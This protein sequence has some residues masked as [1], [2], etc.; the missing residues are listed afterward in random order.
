MKFLSLTILLAPLLNTDK[1]STIKIF[2]SKGN[3]K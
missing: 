2:R 3:L 1:M